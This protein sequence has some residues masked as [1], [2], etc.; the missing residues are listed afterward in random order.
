MRSPPV[1]G[2]CVDR[3]DK[4]YPGSNIL[5]AY[6]VDKAPSWVLGTEMQI[7]QHLPK[8]TSIT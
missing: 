7:P 2:I 3:R 8:R 4:A 1:G 6:T 5:W